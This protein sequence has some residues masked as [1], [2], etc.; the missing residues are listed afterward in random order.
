MPEHDDPPTPAIVESE[1]ATTAVIRGVVPADEL[2]TFFDRSFTRL[3]AVIADQGGTIVG[4]AF[5]RYHRP[6]TDTADLE[7]GF[8]TAA[9]ISPSGDV[10][11]GSLPGG[12]VARV[13]HAGSFDG[14]TSSWARLR[15][16]IDEQ[17]LTVGPALWE[18]YLTEPSPEMDPADLRTEL[19]WS[20]V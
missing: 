7:V 17:E 10:A 6:L 14:L 1:A 12:R 18:V 15:T 3:A 16:W 4:P 13:V 2:A 8:T 19:N 5:A 11:V 9:P 20:L